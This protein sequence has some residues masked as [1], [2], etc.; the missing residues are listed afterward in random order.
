MNGD[1]H[2]R[3]RD[4]K[5]AKKEAAQRI[6]A[7][8]AGRDPGHFKPALEVVQMSP[9]FRRLSHAARSLL[10]DIMFSNPYN[11]ALSASMKYLEPLGWKS[12]DL[13]GRAL[14]E[15]LACGLLHETRKGRRP[16]VAARYAL[17]WMD[18][19]ADTKE[20]DP[21]AVRT[22][23]RGAYLLPEMP[24]RVLRIGR[25]AAA[26]NARKLS[27]KL[28]RAGY[29]P[30]PSDGPMDQSHCTVR[31]SPSPSIGPSDGAVR[32][33]QA[34]PIAPSDGT[35]L[36]NHH[37]QAAPAAASLSAAPRKSNAA[38]RMGQVLQRVH[39]VPIAMRPRAYMTVRLKLKRRSGE[40]AATLQGHAGSEV[41]Q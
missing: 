37:L 9:G 25:T 28:K 35:Y 20:L 17:T 11:G 12:R 40:Q 13:V 30:A 36:D 29:V 27:A 26:T 5:R 24:P 41:G 15:L 19:A 14:R 3:L 38:T 31:R 10:W 16:N 7:A 8:K 39:P 4:E 2:I 32:P 23:Q 6:K 21:E 18:I 1:L 34:P 33:L 22:F